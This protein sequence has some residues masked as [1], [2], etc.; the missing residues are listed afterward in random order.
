MSYPPVFFVEKIA[1]IFAHFFD[2]CLHDN[3][4]KKKSHKPD[5]RSRFSVH[6]ILVR[7]KF[8]ISLD[9]WPFPSG[10]SEG[11]KSFLKFLDSHPK[12]S[13]KTVHIG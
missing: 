3:N 1:E 6:T 8:G 11:Y 9:F 2:F 7:R 5:F 13:W 12:K 4:E 10:V